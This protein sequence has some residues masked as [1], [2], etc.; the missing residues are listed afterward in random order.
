MEKALTRR[1]RRRTNL[2]LL[3]ADWTTRGHGRSRSDA[4][5]VMEDRGDAALAWR[6]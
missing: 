2:S 5:R 6:R 3:A 4:A 1:R